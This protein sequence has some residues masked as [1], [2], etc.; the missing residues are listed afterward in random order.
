MLDEF[1]SHPMAS[2]LYDIYHKINEAYYSTL[3]ERIRKVQLCVNQRSPLLVTLLGFRFQAQKIDPGYSL[4]FV[5]SSITRLKGL[6]GPRKRTRSLPTM[7]HLSE[8]LGS[9][10]HE[11]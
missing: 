9:R 3:N 2:S 1:K 5:N 11:R 8:Q 10:R 7:I 6:R 4:R